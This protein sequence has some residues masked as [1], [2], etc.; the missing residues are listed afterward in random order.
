MTLIRSAQRMCLSCS[1]SVEHG[2]TCP[3]CGGHTFEFGYKFIKKLAKVKKYPIP[4]RHSSQ[5]KLDFD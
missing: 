2:N 3:S 1:T 4:Q 5:I